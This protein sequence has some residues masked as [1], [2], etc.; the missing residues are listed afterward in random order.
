MQRLARSLSSSF[1]LFLVVQIMVNDRFR[2]RSLWVKDISL[3]IPTK[4]TFL[5][6]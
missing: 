5:V 3:G 1:M 4:V 2:I 6:C